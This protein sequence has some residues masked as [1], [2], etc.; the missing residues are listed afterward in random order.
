[1]RLKG[2]VDEFRAHNLEMK[3]QNKLLEKEVN[4]VELQKQALKDTELSLIE[5]IHKN[6]ENLRKLQEIEDRM[7]MVGTRGRSATNKLIGKTKAINKQWRESLKVQQRDMLHAAYNLFERQR[8]RRRDLGMTDYQEFKEILPKRIKSGF[9]N[10][11]NFDEIVRDQSI[12][13]FESFA[14]IVDR[15][16]L[17]LYL[18]SISECDLIP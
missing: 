8:T 9:L 15:Y 13:G 18:R 1:M 5:G 12:V 7:K 14:Q 16:G 17:C 2:K 6:E 3:R 11:T 4:R 10:K